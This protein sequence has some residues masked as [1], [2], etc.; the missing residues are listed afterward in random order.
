MAINIEKPV[1]G[2]MVFERYKTKHIND[3][4]NEINIESFALFINLI[5][6]V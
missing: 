2:V 3:A 1:K 4:K 5:F 6:L